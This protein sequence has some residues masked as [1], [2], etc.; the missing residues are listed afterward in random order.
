MINSQNSEGY[1]YYYY[2]AMIEIISVNSLTVN[3]FY[4][5]YLSC[6]QVNCDSIIS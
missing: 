4:R 1:Y 5:D 3:T 2:F 6:R